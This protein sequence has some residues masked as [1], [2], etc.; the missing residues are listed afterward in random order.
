M[1]PRASSGSDAQRADP[2]PGARTSRVLVQGNGERADAPPPRTADGAWRKLPL[3]RIYQGTVH[4]TRSSFPVKGFTKNSSGAFCLP[5]TAL[6]LFAFRSDLRSICARGH[7]GRMISHEPE[8]A[9]ILLDCPLSPLP[10]ETLVRAAPHLNCLT[11]GA[12][13]SRHTRRGSHHAIAC[14]LHAPLYT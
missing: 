12:A 5:A 8:S 4:S 7:T 14:Q 10:L 11:H 2:H 1:A 13:C 6:G 9:W 3:A